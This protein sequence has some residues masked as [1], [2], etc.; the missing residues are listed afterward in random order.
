VLRK[1]FVFSKE[2][3]LPVSLIAGV[4]NGVTCLAVDADDQRLHAA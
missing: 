1:G 4:D 2:M 3:E